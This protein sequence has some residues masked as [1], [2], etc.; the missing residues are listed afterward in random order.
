MTGMRPGVKF[1]LWSPKFTN[2]PDIEPPA[3]LQFVGTFSILSA[4]GF[5]VFAVAIVI[6]PYGTNYEPELVEGI[7]VATLHFILPIG[8]FYTVMV[9]SPLSRYVISIHIVTLAAATIAGKGF[10]GQLPLLETTRIVVSAAMT[11]IVLG[12]LY[13]SPKMRFYYAVVAG[14]PIP[15][16]LRSRADELRG[17]LH[18]DP[19]VRAALEWFI[20]RVEIAV[21]LG[22]IILVFYAFWETG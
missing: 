21:M 10:L 15:E 1:K 22:F 9:N 13:G 5:L 12:W 18:L 16:D 11:V 4:F 19:R 2:R 3:L 8:I 6:V 17:G 7:Y 20:D 14:K